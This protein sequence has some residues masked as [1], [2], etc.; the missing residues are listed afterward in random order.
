MVGSLDI[1][2]YMFKDCDLVNNLLGLAPFADRACTSAFRPSQFQI[3]PHNG[4]TPILSGTRDSAR[5]LW[6]VNLGMKEK[7][8]RS[9]GIPPPQ[10]HSA[11]HTFS[12]TSVPGVYIEANHA[13]LHD[14]AS[15]VRFIHAC[16]G[17]PAP[18]T[19]LRAVT[20]GFITGL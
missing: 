19:F 15:Y 2:A 11:H 16:L 7:S 1:T 5:S 8:P 3:Y 13:A 18:T 12:A 6:L 10:T 4:S 9:D 17:Y 20:A 14:N